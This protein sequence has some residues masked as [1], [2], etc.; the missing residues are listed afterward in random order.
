[1]ADVADFQKTMKLIRHNQVLHCPASGTT[2]FLTQPSAVHIYV[3][4]P[5]KR[6]SK[7]SQGAIHL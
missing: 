7:S 4:L 3:D 6:A 1:M 2:K 5:R